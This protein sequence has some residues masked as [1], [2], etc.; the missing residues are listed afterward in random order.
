MRLLLLVIFGFLFSEKV[1]SQTPDNSIKDIKAYVKRIDSLSDIKTFLASDKAQLVLKI[2]EG[3][4]ENKKR[5]LKGG[6]SNETITNPGMDTLYLFRRHDNLEMNL[7]ESYYY[8]SGKLVF[9][10]IELKSEDDTN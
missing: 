2:S 3:Q 1:S 6:F 10:K 7:Y 9:S 8:T 5:G 4:I